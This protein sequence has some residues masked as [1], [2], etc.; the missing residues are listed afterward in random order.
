MKYVLVLLC[1][2]SLVGCKIIYESD[3]SEA[4]IPAG[5]EGDD[6]R[7]AARL[8]ATFETELLPLVSDRALSIADLRAEID[9]GIDIAGEAHGNRGAGQGVAWNFAVS[10]TGEIIDANLES[11]ARTADVDV[12]GNGT[13][14]VRLQLGPVIRGTT[15]RD[16]APF[17][18]FD[19]FRDQIEFARLARAINDRMNARLSIPES[20]L[21]GRSVS[22]T[23]AA[24]MRS[25]D[26][27]LVITLTE[28]AVLP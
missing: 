21:I 22:F 20:D 12:D 9:I 3:E 25:A 24:P 26:D 19:D 28:F 5:Q 11:S 7:N 10:D 16:V 8:D 15:L 2:L 17:Y 4:A 1:A 14:D 18:N 23:G 13:P 27:A 6:A